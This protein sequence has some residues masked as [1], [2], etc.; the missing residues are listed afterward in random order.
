MYCFGNINF[1][2]R[3]FPVFHFLSRIRKTKLGFPGAE[4][5][6]SPVGPESA[7]LPE[8]PSGWAR[9][10]LKLGRWVPFCGTWVL[11]GQEAGDGQSTG[12]SGIIWGGAVGLEALELVG[13][14]SI[15]GIL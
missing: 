14:V 1:C 15:K 9:A 2:K 10:L 11:S 12:N 7:G 5:A 8:L 6:D 13:R 4:A 3:R